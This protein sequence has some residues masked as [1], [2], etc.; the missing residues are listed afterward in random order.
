MIVSIERKEH[1]LPDFLIVGAPR[2]G[3]TTLYNCLSQ[4]RHIYM[5]PE[6]EPTFFLAWGEAPFY[7]DPRYRREASHIVHEVDE[8]LR[9]FR[10]ARDSDVIGEA[11]ALYL[12]GHRTVIPNIKK[13]YGGSVSRV[14]IIISLRN[15]VD[16]ASSQYWMKRSQY[17]ETSDFAEAT[18]PGTV[19][20]RLERRLIPSFDYV[21]M[22]KYSDAVSAYRNVF[23][24]VKIILFEDIAQDLPGTIT[25]LLTY[26]GLSTDGPP[27]KPA[28]WNASGLAKNPRSRLMADFLF[29][30]NAPKSVLKLFLPQ[31]F[32]Q[33]WKSSMGERIFAK[34][35]LDDESRQR[36]QDFY[37]DDIR[38]LEKLIGR[39]LQRWLKTPG[40]QAG[41]AAETERA[42]KAG[43]QEAPMPDAG[44]KAC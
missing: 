1:K 39:D 31:R 21:G 10:A 3:T 14:K 42:M 19:R 7:K 43:C 37:R 35:S 15:P 16:R 33:R 26:L 17:E 25:S 27:V 34:Q 8:Y 32:R 23:P 13:V 11:S 6:K 44:G 9:L 38:R 18:D 30:P 5:P 22:G 28:R 20:W 12:Y 24:D 2:S 36:L 40:P 29:R 4:H 41:D